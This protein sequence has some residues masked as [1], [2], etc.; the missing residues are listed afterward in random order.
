MLASNEVL[1]LFFAAVLAAAGWRNRPFLRDIWRDPDVLWRVTIRLA[2]AGTGLLAL[3]ITFADSWRQLSGEPY[4]SIQVWESHRQVLDPP[5][6]AVRTITVV[7]L[8]ASVLLVAAL[9]SRH[10]GGIGTAFLVIVAGGAFW[11]PLFVVRTRLNVDLAYGFTG[12]W[13]DPLAVFG[14]LIFAF[15]ALLFES[16]LIL[17]TYLLIV[18]LAAVPLTIVLGLLG[19]REPKTRPETSAWYNSL[20]DPRND[21]SS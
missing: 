9:F 14:H 5:S 6:A 20:G 13:T 21:R 15:A 8:V 19:L 4:R 3:W 17:V 18:A 1:G 2:A 10:V 12:S 16:A 7:L 11:I